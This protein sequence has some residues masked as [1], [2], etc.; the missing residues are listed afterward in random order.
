MYL[1]KE[2]GESLTYEFAKAATEMKSNGREIISL[3]LGE[4]D[5]PTPSYILDATIEAMKNGFT[6]YS[7]PQGLPE[8][9]ELIAQKSTQDY[10]VEYV[11]DETIVLPG[12]KAALFMGLASILEPF[13]KIVVITPYYVSYP[14]IIKLAE[15]TASIIN[16]KLNKDYSLNMD[17]LIDAL[18]KKPKC[19][20]VNTPHNPTGTVFKKTEVEE[21]VKRCAENDVYIISDEVYEKLTYCDFEHVSFARYPDIKNRLIVANGYSKS[22]AMTGWRLGYAIGPKDIIKRMNKL[23]QHINTNTCTFVQKGAC[24]IYKNE[25]SHIEP[26]VR[27]LQKRAG[28][29]HNALNNNGMFKGI[30]PKAGFFYF[31]NISLTGMDSNSFCIKLLQE[32]GI[33]TTPGIAFGRDWDDHI[34]FSLA[35]QMKTLEKAVG[36]LEEFRNKAVD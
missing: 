6:H 8:L 16:I 11:A 26:Y 36:L 20:L 28:F 30:K 3:G 12:I 15:P 31:A 21:I 10:G 7:A 22:H 1:A 2:V 24:S 17:A 9:R 14:A 34:R 19:I 35:V 33:A 29:F 23:Q 32:T 25:P 13:D 4:P 27:E 5:F 18:N